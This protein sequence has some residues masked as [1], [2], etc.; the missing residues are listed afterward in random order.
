MNVRELWEIH[1]PSK[2]GCQDVTLRE[3]Q[4]ETS[5]SGLGIMG[6]WQTERGQHQK[7]M[8]QT[9]K[10]KSPQWDSYECRLTQVGMLETQLPQAAWL[11]VIQSSCN[12]PSSPILTVY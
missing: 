8:K 11:S 2:P 1:A 10:V 5:V 3:M 12:L 9:L 4:L 7:T 6:G